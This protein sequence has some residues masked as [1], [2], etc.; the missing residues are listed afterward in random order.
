MRE[1]VELR[2]G[3]QDV[4]FEDARVALCAPFGLALCCALEAA[5]Q[6]VVEEGICVAFVRTP[7]IMRES[8]L[9]SAVRTCEL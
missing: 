4:G 7:G 9:S 8:W 2:L 1:S 6:P 3:A 5:D